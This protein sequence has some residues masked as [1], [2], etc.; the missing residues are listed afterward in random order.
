MF[1]KTENIFSCRQAFAIQHSSFLRCLLLVGTGCYVALLIGTVIIVP[2][3]ELE[4]VPDFHPI[5]GP[6]GVSA[7]CQHFFEVSFLLQ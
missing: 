3:I 1:S 5:Q 2:T 4:A 7:F 6:H